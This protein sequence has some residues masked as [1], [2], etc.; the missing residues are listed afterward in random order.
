M[1]ECA[2]IMDEELQLFFEELLP[3]VNNRRLNLELS[4]QQHEEVM[5]LVSS[6]NILY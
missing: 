1:M 6:I 2:E 5:S 4:E 3:H